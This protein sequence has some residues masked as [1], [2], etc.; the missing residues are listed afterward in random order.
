MFKSIRW[1]LQVW[2]AAILL[3]AVAGFGAVLYAQVR[4]ARFDEIDADLRA[5]A[6]SLEGALR[7]SPPHVLEGKDAP[8]PPPPR[9]LRP[10]APGSPPPPPR[11]GDDRHG[12]RPP[13][14]PPSLWG[15]LDEALTLPEH[16][17]GR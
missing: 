13:G 8:P 1:R 11:D 16:F 10:G 14:A 3:L 12:P 6:G 9:G 17:R 2:H 5:A 4:R 7:G 15:H